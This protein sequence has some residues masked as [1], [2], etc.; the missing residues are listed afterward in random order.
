MGTSRK[1]H[2]SPYKPVTVKPSMGGKLMSNIS[3][4]SVGIPNYVVK[5]DFRRVL[6]HEVRSEGYDY[7]WP[8]TA[9]PIANQPFPQGLTPPVTPLPITL[10]HQARMPNGALAVICGTATTLYRYFSLSDGHYYQG[11]GTP[12]EYFNSND[13]NGPYYQSV[14][15]DWIVIGSGFQAIAQRWEAIDVNGL[16]VLNNGVDLPMTYAVFDFAVKPIYELREV[17]IAAVG[18]IT[19]SNGYLLCADVHQI[20]DDALVDLLS[21]I[22]AGTVTASQ[23]GSYGPSPFTATMTGGVVTSAQPIFSMASVNQTIQF[24]NGVATLITGYI[25]ST[26]VNVADTSTVISPGVEFFLVNPGTTDYTVVASAPFFNAGMVGEMIVWDAGA[27]RTIQSFVDSTHVIVDTN[28]SI[29]SGTFGT[30]NPL[31][32]AVY[33]DT[34]NIDRIQYRIINGIP[35][36]ARRW[37]ATVP[38]SITAGSIILQLQYPVQ[39]FFEL[40]GSQITVL[41]AG[42]TG[43]NLTATLVYLS[44]DAMTAILDTPAVTTVTAA[45][46]QAADA[47]GANIG[48]IDLQD[49]GSGIIGMLDLLGNLIVYKDTSIFLGTYTGT[50]GAPFNFTNNT[51]YRGS[52]TLYYRNTLVQVTAKGQ[53][54]HIFAGRTSFYRYDLV[55]QQP[56]E[57]ETLEVCK[58]IFYNSVQ[59]P[60]PLDPVG[61]FAFDNPITKEI[62]FCMPESEGPDY[63]LRF[64]YFN[65]QASSSSVKC[66]TAGCAIKRPESGLQVGTTE[67]WVALGL[68]NGTMTVY[69]L[70]GI[71]IAE[72]DDPTVPVSSS[73]AF[74][75]ATQSGNTITTIAPFFTTDIAVG[76]SIQWPDLSVVNVV[77]YLSPTQILVG[78]PPV[79]RALTPF[80]VISAI[81]HRLG[82]PYTSVQQSGLDNF[83][84]EF[85]E[86]DLESWIISLASLS[87]NTAFFFELIGGITPNYFATDPA[88]RPSVLGSF[89]FTNPRIQSA[90]GMLFCQN[91]FQDRITVSGIN[92][93]FQISARLYNIAGVNSKAFTRR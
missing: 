30:T 70:T 18:N 16:T 41:G 81:W 93:P 63:A 59:V 82:K 55:Y 4:D 27:S 60:Q 22:S 90:I 88:R 5:R 71:G 43:G 6:D 75:Q 17:G 84:N 11:D 69:G 2:I 36:E 14:Y 52:K 67:D 15:G 33:N 48:F 31:A 25:D 53:Q 19:Q 74:V 49:D 44:P 76:Q 73:Y 50:I 51:V 29:P 61:V 56:M 10:I 66:V 26:H 85:G 1:F 91:Y 32:Y 13:P 79:T 20:D 34:N 68:Q 58:D 46:V 72:A 54:F 86:K 47:T 12:Q 89:T 83:G 3:A 64:D 45:L 77:Q 65:I 8:N 62:W 92:N 7:F 42:T 78:G 57:V 9:L 39:S 23:V 21:L 24:T 87:P 38:G 28:F 40:V 80:S 37:G 35:F